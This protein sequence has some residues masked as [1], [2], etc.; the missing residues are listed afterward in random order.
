ME[1]GNFFELEN[2]DIYNLDYIIA[3]SQDESND[4]RFL[5]YY[6][7]DI[8]IYITNEEYEFIRKLIKKFANSY[9]IY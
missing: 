2:G 7:G 8:C 4:K 6:K 3:I 9:N 1:R 5:M